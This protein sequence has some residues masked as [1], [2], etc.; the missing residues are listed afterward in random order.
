MSACDNDG[1]KYMKNIR[2]SVLILSITALFSMSVFAQSG[3]SAAIKL[4]DSAEFA[5]SKIS[6]KFLRVIEDSRCP[7][8]VNCIWAGN[9]MIEIE[10]SKG[11]QK[12]TLILNT[13][14]NETEAKFE[15]YTIKL[16]GLEPQKKSPKGEPEN[17][18]EPC[19][20]PYKATFTVAKF[21]PTQ[22]AS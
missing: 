21:R 14:G 3:E 20:I 15:G 1:A 16:A 17:E 10:A 18:Q 19:G 9:A 12:S 2:F 6:I 5:A 13:N 4:G 22:E 8:D 7:A 11:S